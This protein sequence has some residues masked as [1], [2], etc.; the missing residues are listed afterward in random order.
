MESIWI[1]VSYCGNPLLNH[2]WFTSL[3]GAVERALEIRGELIRER[4]Q[5][6]VLSADWMKAAIVPNADTYS[7]LEDVLVYPSKAV[8][9]TSDG[10]ENW[11]D[12]IVDLAPYGV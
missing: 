2:G 1:L 3:E 5:S 12:S 11:Y 4:E 7:R 10:S 8:C 9:I 6:E